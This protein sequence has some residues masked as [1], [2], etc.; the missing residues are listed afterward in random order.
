MLLASIL[1]IVAQIALPK[2]LFTAQGFLSKNSSGCAFKFAT[3]S[4]QLAN[5]KLGLDWIPIYLLNILWISFGC[6][7]FCQSLVESKDP[8]EIEPLIMLIHNKLPIDLLKFCQTPQSCFSACLTT[9]RSTDRL[10]NNLP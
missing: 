4:F 8:I 5:L 7:S 1:S 6:Q 2:V 9:D 10:L 3:S